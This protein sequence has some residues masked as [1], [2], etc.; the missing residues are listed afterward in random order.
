MPDACCPKCGVKLRVYWCR[1]EGA[2][3]AVVCGV[4]HAAMFVGGW[5]MRFT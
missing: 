3:S 5:T 1:E 2:W 4:H